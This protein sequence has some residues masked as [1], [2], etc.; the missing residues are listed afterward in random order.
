VGSATDE[1]AEDGEQLQKDRGRVSLAVGSYGSD[2]ESGEAVECGGVESGIRDGPGCGFARC[3]WRRGFT[4]RWE[5]GM[6]CGRLGVLFRLRL[7][8]EGEEL[9]AAPVYVGEGG[10]IGALWAVACILLHG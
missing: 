8:Q 2:G 7:R 10:S 4:G 3:F 9:A 5:L 1:V 6:E